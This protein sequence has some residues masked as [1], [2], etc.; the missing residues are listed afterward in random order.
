MNN[1][2]FHLIN[3]QAGLHPALDLMLAL[4]EQNV[5]WLI[6]ALLL[7]FWFK[8]NQRSTVYS[9]LT[10]ILA[11]VFGQ[12]ISH[13]YPHPRPFTVEAT[14]HQLIPHA[15]D[16]SFPSDHALGTFALAFAIWRSNR[17]WG[18]GLLVLAIITGLG[19][20]YAGVHYPADIVG[21]A[22]VALLAAFL[23]IRAERVLEPFVQLLLNLYGKAA[24]FLPIKK[25]SSHSSEL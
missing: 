8:G 10:V 6:A 14:V 9:V 25:N 4:F 23:V 21:G 24:A 22:I 20:I 1:T 17:R 5:H 7:V 11:L 2:I 18:A 19:R 13:I 16:N 15:P 3:D 12:I